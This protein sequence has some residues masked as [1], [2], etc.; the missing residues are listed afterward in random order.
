MSHLLMAS[1]WADTAA[2]VELLR[3]S[4]ISNGASVE[5]VAKEQGVSSAT[6]YKH[7]RRHLHGLT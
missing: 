2:R 6:V 7:M 3:N 4:G 5:Q 1:V